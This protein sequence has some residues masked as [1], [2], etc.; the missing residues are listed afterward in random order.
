MANLFAQ[1]VA[2]LSTH[3]DLQACIRHW[4]AG[5]AAAPDR[6]A[7]SAGGSAPRRR[8]ILLFGADARHGRAPPSPRT[9]ARVGSAG[10]AD[11][12]PGGGQRPHICAPQGGS[13]PGARADVT[14]SLDQAGAR[15]TT[16]RGRARRRGRPCCRRARTCAT[17]AGFCRLQC[18]RRAVA[19]SV[20]VEPGTRLDRT[21]EGPYRLTM[22]NSERVMTIR[23]A[24]LAALAVPHRPGLALA[25]TAALRPCLPPRTLSR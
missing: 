18:E 2:H 6:P 19:V 23:T 4:F 25:Q 16:D 10:A 13:A 15:A 1:L 12:S 21:R 5:D 9:Q 8:W 24:A 22:C 7:A 14:G 3:D 17:G 20:T 11:L